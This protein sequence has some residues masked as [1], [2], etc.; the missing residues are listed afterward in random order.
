MRKFTKKTNHPVYFKKWQN[1]KYAAFNSLGKSIVIC[2]L[3]VCYS[4]VVVPRQASA[5]NSDTVIVNNA[6]EID[7]VV[8]TAERDEANLVEIGRTIT[9]MTRNEVEQSASQ[10]LA[11]VLEHA[12]GIDLRQRGVHGAQADLS[13]RGGS[14]D[15]VKIFLNGIALN[16]PQTGHHHLNLPVDI[17]NIEKIEILNGLGGRILGP[18]AFSGAVNIVTRQFQDDYLG[19]SLSGGQFGYY[20]FN[21]DASKSYKKITNYLSFS[22]INSNGYM[23]NT[24]F[25]R[26]ILYYNGM[27]T[28]D[29]FKLSWQGGVNNNDFGANSF[30]TADFP[31]QFESTTTYFASIK[32]N[33]GNKIKFTPKLYWRRNY[34]RFE[35]FRESLYQKEVAT[36]LYIHGN[37]TAGFT[38]NPGQVPYTGHNYHQ[39][40]ATGGEFTLNYQ[41][42][43]GKTS[44]GAGFRSEQML[45]SNLEAARL[46]DTIFTTNEEDGFYLFHDRRNQ[47]N[48][49]LDHV[50]KSRFF[51]IS[52]GILAHWNENLEKYSFLPGKFRLFPGLN[53]SIKINESI[54]L[55]AAYNSSLRMP[56]FTDLYY[57]GPT[58]TGNPYLKPE[59][60]QTI[61][62]GIK[63][64]S[65]G[66]FAGISI[67][68]RQADNVI[69][70][71]KQADTLLWE[72]RNIT[73]INTAGIE[74]SGKIDLVKLTQNEDLF[75]KDIQLNYSYID[76]T[77]LSGDFISKY[78]L[79][80]LKHKFSISV[81]NHFF[82]H[83]YGS[84][85]F[86][87]QDRAGSFSDALTGA[88]TTYDPYFLLNGKIYL[89]NK[90]YLVY[91]EGNNLLNQKYFDIGN[92]VQPGIWIK[93]GTKV[94]FNFRESK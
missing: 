43:P 29:V 81:T 15:Q 25:N 24:D 17:E 49:Y 4:L 68:Y 69:D 87:A 9:I 8:L 65:S 33:A 83:I 60:S 10:S 20:K 54:N 67:F 84:Y 19:A 79:D 64:F 85:R 82:W 55:F 91:I 2:S 30:Y 76:Q 80:Y 26:N 94:N 72:S 71:V 77:K 56:T 86:T 53:A 13:I 57:N 39:T 32:A 1:K 52:G 28:C 3:S 11:D 62:G 89:K 37:D 22:K 35:L 12:P 31:D 40:D 58:N 93:V 42:A 47:W 38:S 21:V 63:Y 75:L 14:I 70:W 36:G 44:I 18:N 16:D 5:Q 27:W 48:I 78:A 51:S 92:V 88:E 73:K 90:W 6:E 74:F 66:L 46:K 23:N 41:W 45:S 61:E 59:F 50:F 34:D 7:E